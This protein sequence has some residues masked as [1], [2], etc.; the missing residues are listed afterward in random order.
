MRRANFA[1]RYKKCIY[2]VLQLASV[3]KIL[4]QIH[5]FTGSNTTTITLDAFHNDTARMHYALALR[6]RWYLATNYF[7][8]MRFSRA[9]A[10][11]RPLRFCSDAFCKSR[12][13]ALSAN[14]RP[15][16]R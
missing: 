8:T 5:N 6:H 13:Q 7:A 14:R 9:L 10:F 4:H 16:P 15:L 2:L 3:E 11:F 1:L 12:G